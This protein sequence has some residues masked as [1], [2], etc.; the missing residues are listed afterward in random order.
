MAIGFRA[1]GALATRASSTAT[2]LPVS[3]PAGT[4]ADDLMLLLATSY[5]ANTGI[6]TPAGWTIIDTR[7]AWQT[8]YRTVL[9]W[10][11]AGASESSVSMTTA[12]ASFLDAGIVG[13]TGTDKTTPIDVAGTWTAPASG[14]TVTVPSIT[15]TTAN[16]W[17]LSLE[18][19]SAS[20][21]NASSFPSG[22]TQRFLATGNVV[23]Y[24][25]NSVAV[26]SA[27]ATTATSHTRTTSLA[28]YITL[29]VAL[30][31]AVSSFVPQIIAVI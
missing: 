29:G 15:T 28:G 7:S 31:A 26:A 17:W 2:A 3:V 25:V 11:V 10:K 18:T 16:T 9:Y 19:D 12:A 22:W 27:G 4:T 14:T 1:A 5:P 23:Q 8:D 6:N 13:F 30:R 24:L 21:M 20:G